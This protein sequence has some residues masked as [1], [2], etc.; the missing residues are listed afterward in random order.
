[1]TESH[2]DTTNIEER[3]ERQNDTLPSSV[4]TGMSV[5]STY[6]TTTLHS[7]SNSDS[8]RHDQ[9]SLQDPV[10]ETLPTDMSDTTES[11]GEKH[12]VA[13]MCVCVLCVLCVYVLCMFV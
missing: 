7:I 12:E 8:A 10:S 11:D 2:I 13:G 6:T 9:P 5:H 3:Q 4:T 1:V